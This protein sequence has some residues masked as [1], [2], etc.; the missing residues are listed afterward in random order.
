MVAIKNEK[1]LII[2]DEPEILD[3]LSNLLTEEGYKVR[4]ALGGEETIETFKSEPFGLVITDIR[5]PGIDGLEVMKRVKQ[6][7]EDIEVIILTGFANMENAIEAL[8]GDGAFNYLT[9]PLENID[10]FLNTIRQALEKRTL[11]IMNKELLMNLEKEI[12]AQKRAKEQIYKSKMV[13]QSI[14]DG[15]SDLNII[16]FDEKLH[17]KMLNRAAAQYYKVTFEDAVGKSCKDVLMKMCGSC[18][19]CEVYSS[20]KTGNRTSIERKSPMDDNRIERV[21]IYP[22]NEKG[23]KGAIV[24]IDD[25]TVKKAAEEQLKR[26]DRLSSLGQLSGGFA[27]EIRNPLAGMSLFLEILSDGKNFQHTE[28]ELNIIQEVKEG[29]NKISDIVKRVI[30]FARFS[31]L[32]FGKIDINAL[33]KEEIR[34]WSEK[35]RNSNIQLILLLTDDLPCV[36]GDQISLQQAI[37]NVV[38]NAIEAMGKGGNLNIATVKGV[39]S[40]RKNQEVVI[41]NITDTGTGIKPENL[42]SVFNPFFSTKAIGKGLGLSISN[43]TI[44]GHGGHIS[45]QSKPG[46]GTTFTIELPCMSAK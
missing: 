31:P 16:M 27:H 38:L 32:S 11:K 7:D 13:L 2:D 17:V 45:V 1:I 40:F 20:I 18:E 46:D 23:M 22:F 5:M 42:E 36:Y 29:V 33:I 25:I 26:A 41:I 14:I 39:S 24:R 30:N 6:L 35:L 10:Q 4:T 3:V 15:I 9:K 44:E 37:N 43:K 28:E 8:R 34:M 21:N 19:Q 12:E